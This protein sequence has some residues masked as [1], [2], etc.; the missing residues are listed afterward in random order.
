MYIADRITVEEGKMGGVPCIRGLRI[1]VVTVVKL[2]ANGMTT[3]EILRDYPSLEAA[4]I[5]AALLFAA[6]CMLP[7]RVIP[8]R[9]TGS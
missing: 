3:E 4:D 6:E 9:P 5:K 8:L 1:P 2:V 7:T